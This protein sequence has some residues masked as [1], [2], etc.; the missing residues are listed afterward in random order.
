MRFLM[1]QVAM[2]K[3]FFI[4]III[5]VMGALI[6]VLYIY[7]EP[8]NKYDKTVADFFGRDILKELKHKS[9]KEEIEISNQILNYAKEVSEGQVVDDSKLYKFYSPYSYNGCKRVELNVEMITCKISGDEGH[10]WVKT[11]YKRYDKNDEVFSFGSVPLSLWYIKK[12][13]Q[14]W[15]VENIKE[16]V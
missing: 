16:P 6:G 7:Y 1:M 5:V 4:V 10:L 9:N 3:E 12:V 15:V 2:N 11:H 8:I 13:N 14:K